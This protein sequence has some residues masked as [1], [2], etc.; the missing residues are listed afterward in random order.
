MTKRKRGAR[1]TEKHEET[2]GAQQ[3]AATP[4]GQRQVSL[5]ALV[6]SAGGVLMGL[7]IA[8]SRVLA[9]HFGN[10]IFVWGSLISIFLIALSVGN[11]LGGVLAD[12]YPSRWVLHL[13]CA[14]VSLWIFGIAVVGYPFCLWLLELGA[15]E[16]SGP[17]WAS[18]VLFLAPSIGMGIVSPFAIRLAT[19]SV[20]AVGKTSG[21]FYAVST[22]GSI[23]GTLLT[24]FVLIPLI[25]LASILKGLGAVLLVVSIVTMPGR[26][27]LF[28][29]AAVLL[30]PL[31]GWLVPG[32]GSVLAR[33]D[34]T[35]VVDVDTPYHHISV[36]DNAYRGSRELRF[37][38][39]VESAIETTPPYRSLTDYT[40]YFS[41]AFLVRPSL[42]R[43]L[44]IGAGGAIGPRA[45][46][47]HDPKMGIDV[48]DI[49]PEILRIAFTD[50]FL[51]ASPSLRTFA[52]DGRMFLRQSADRYDC[53][54]LD[55]FTI[56][57]RIPFHLVT[58]EFFQ[59]CSARMADDG[60]LLINLNSALAGRLS[61][62]FQSVH[63]TVAAVFPTVYVFAEHRFE[64]PD[65]SRNVILVGSKS[66]R[67]L[68]RDEWLRRATA[69]E[70]ASYVDAR[71]MTRLVGDLM[72]EAEVAT[73]APLLTDDYAPIETMSF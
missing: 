47:M 22:L 10:S 4:S 59:A 11:Y 48:V 33:R 12:R 34:E 42:E 44:F 58:R 7:E 25:G 60:V 23:A 64:R 38:R 65:A 28:G 67:R 31:A 24:T 63:R 14:I 41:L 26:L 17:L 56:G 71:V 20:T 49:D 3:D 5:T 1:Q 36:I 69:F 53:V 50:F 6:F 72:D 57:G 9:P 40:D 43:T 70:T 51:E 45:F 13:V 15:Q 37:D 52:M 29:A 16:Q 8:G 54:V 27:S 55:A 62:I 68:A 61:E 21:T 35:L 2:S 46:Q 73:A 19:P 30:V 39:Y 32:G 66:E 18:A